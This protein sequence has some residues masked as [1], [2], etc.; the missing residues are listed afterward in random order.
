VDPVKRIA[1]EL[2]SKYAD[3]FS[4]DF[5]H[6]KR[7]LNEIANVHSKQFRNELAGYITKLVKRSKA[8]EV[9]AYA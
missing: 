5:E 6:N 2:L 8:P 7:V 3:R 1:L 4:A 9:P